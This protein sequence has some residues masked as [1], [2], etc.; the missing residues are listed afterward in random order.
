[1]RENNAYY[2]LLCHAIVSD[3]VVASVCTDH[4]S[5]SQAQLKSPFGDS[6]LRHGATR[7]RVKRNFFHSTQ[8][9]FIRD[10]IKLQ[11]MLTTNFAIEAVFNEDL[12]LQF[13]QIFRK[14]NRSAECI[15]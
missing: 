14:T 12:V 10:L 11:Y 1:M 15:R 4:L 8:L 2:F 5:P 13:Y 9:L 7:E 3:N 6:C